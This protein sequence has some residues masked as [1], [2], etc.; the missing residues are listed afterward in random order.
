MVARY[1][2]RRVAHYS[3][4]RAARYCQRLVERYSILSAGWHGILRE[5]WSLCKV[6]RYSAGS[7]S[8]F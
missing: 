7:V 2:A 4:L 8:R 1:S 3:V 5:W 6:A